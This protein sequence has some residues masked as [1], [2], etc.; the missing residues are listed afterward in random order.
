MEI[1]IN[2]MLEHSQYTE[3]ISSWN[4][5]SIISSAR[6]HD[7]GKIA[8]P[9]CILNKPDK[10]TSDEFSII[11]T[12]PI[13]GERIIDQMISRTGDEEFLHNAKL[14]VAFH[15][16]HWDGTG[17]PYGLKKEEIPLQGRMMAVVDVYDALSSK[18]PYKKAF[19]NEETIEIIQKNA[20][21]H[22]DPQITE[23]FCQIKDKIEL[24]KVRISN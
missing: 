2:S 16:E 9:D 10:L 12:H 18:R 1:L 14:F 8:I 19:T 23:I 5:N 7:L 15:H 17:Y 20:G 6:L 21:T 22:L 4:L 11:Q 13:A 24:A 3:E